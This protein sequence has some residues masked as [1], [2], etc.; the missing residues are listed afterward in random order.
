MRDLD[1]LRRA[2]VAT[3][4]KLDEAVGYNGESLPWVLDCREVLLS[5]P[6]L[7]EASG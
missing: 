1:G 4:L 5:Q 2:L 3:G 7:A 6:R